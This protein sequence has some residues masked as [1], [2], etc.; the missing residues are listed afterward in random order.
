[1]LLLVKMV[2][3]YIIF[4][5]S[6]LALFLLSPFSPFGPELTAEGL[7]PNGARRRPIRRRA[8]R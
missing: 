5:D 4:S 8:N 7:G 6:L 3:I 1:M 2:F